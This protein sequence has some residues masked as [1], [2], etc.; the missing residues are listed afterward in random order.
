MYD[1]NTNNEQTPWQD[2]SA[3][4]PVFHH[5]AII[6]VLKL[7]YKLKIMGVQKKS[8]IPAILTFCSGTQ[9]LYL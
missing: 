2:G 5:S 6:M 3:Q 8:N 4:W 1:W 9:G 7:E